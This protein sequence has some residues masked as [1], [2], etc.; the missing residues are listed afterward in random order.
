VTK[1]IYSTPGDSE[2]VLIVHICEAAATIRQKF[3]IFEHPLQ[4]VLCL[5]WHGIEVRGPKIEHLLSIGNKPQLSQNAS[6]FL[7]VLIPSLTQ[8]HFDG[9]W[10]CKDTRST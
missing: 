1:L 6:V 4:S 5:C 10:H 8:T 7:F 9:Q 2:E 3:G